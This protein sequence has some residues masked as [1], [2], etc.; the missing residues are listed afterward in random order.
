MKMIK[1]SA[2]LIDNIDPF[3]KIELAGRTCYKSE[4]KITSDSSKAF[5]Q[6]LIKNGHTA[7]LEHQVF[8]FELN[9]RNNYNQR[10]KYLKYLRSCKFLN[11]TD[12]FDDFELNN[13]QRKQRILVSGNLRAICERNINDP[14]F[15]ELRRKYPDLVYGKAAEPPLSEMNRFASVKAKL[16]NLNDYEDLTQTE[17]YTHCHITLKLTTD[18]GV[19]HELV[20]HRLCSFAQESTRFVNYKE[21]ISIALPADFKEKA[22]EIQEEYEKAFM[23]AETHYCHLIE[24]GETP[25]QARAVLPTALKTEIVVTANM[26]EWH[27]I[28]DLRLNG[29]TGTPHPD[30]KALMIKARPFIEDANP[31]IIP[32]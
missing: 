20:R 18:R 30:M 9:T 17:L 14:I 16:V 19:T 21:G 12:N 7:M 24:M 22:P 27:H 3:K 31:F 4:A 10:E 2:V 29:T 25:Q 23:D 6:R 5:V 28:F 26:S 8:M 11:V 15:R 32:F 1:P 13:V